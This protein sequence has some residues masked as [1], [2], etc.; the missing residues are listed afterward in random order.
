MWPPGDEVAIRSAP[1]GFD[2]ILDNNN[3]QGPAIVDLQPGQYF[4][5]S[6]CQTWTRDG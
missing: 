6:Y 1:N 5:T 4:E 3:T 2:G